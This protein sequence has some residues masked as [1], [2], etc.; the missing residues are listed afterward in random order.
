[1]MILCAI[2]I[3]QF[4]IAAVVVFVLKNLL[5]KELK[6]AAIEKFMALRIDG[7][8]EDIKIYHVGLLSA[9]VKQQLLNEVKRKFENNKVIFEEN[10]ILKGGLV[11]VIG[12]QV[13]DFSLTNRLENFWS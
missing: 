3:L 11:I 6:Q 8:I 1:M 4:L 9:P 13:L 2:V 10:S 12:E 5:D 7:S